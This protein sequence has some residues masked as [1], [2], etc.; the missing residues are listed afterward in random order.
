MGEWQR[1]EGESAEGGV[2]EAGLCTTDAAQQIKIQLARAKRVLQRKAES[3]ARAAKP[4]IPEAGGAPL[5]P[6]VRQRMEG[7]LGG[8]LS[9]VRVHN[10]AESAQ[11]ATAIGARA[12]TD[13]RDVHFNAG[14]YAPDS[15]EGVR[16]LAHELTH[17]VQGQHPGLQRKADDREAT[18]VSNPEDPAEKEADAVG[19]RVADEEHGDKAAQSPAAVS[20]EHLGVS[21][22]IMRAEEEGTQDG[23]TGGQDAEAGAGEN[24]E[25]GAGE[26]A[27]AGTGENAEA[28][29][30][31][32]A[33]AGTGEN[34]E[35]GTGENAE[36]GT[37]ESAGVENA[38]AGGENAE[39][40]PGGQEQGEL[41]EGAIDEELQDVGEKLAELDQAGAEQ[42]AAQPAG[43]EQSG[44][45]QAGPADPA[46]TQGDQGDAAAGGD[47]AGAYGLAT[48]VAMD[49]FLEEARSVQ[50]N[51][52]DMSPED[53]MGDLA[54][55]ANAELVSA[56][57]CPLDFGLLDLGFLD[58]K[59]DRPNW[60]MVLNKPTFEKDSINQD[61]AANLAETVYHEARHAEQTNSVARMLVG[62]QMSTPEI[63]AKLNVP[64]NV[65]D[66]A[67]TK[68]ID[69]QSPEA[70]LAADVYKSEYGENKEETKAVYT[71]YQ[72]ALIALKNAQQAMK[73]AVSGTQEY[74]DA[75][76]EYNQAKREFQGAQR[77]YKSLPDEQDAYDV[78]GKLKNKFLAG[79]Q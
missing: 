50:S 12:F 19:E 15:K 17:V 43:A 35:A 10:G 23:E 75:Q 36:A 8:D 26:N 29:T 54:R 38:Q 1:R 74:S 2:A 14:Q 41:P 18:E 13:G 20:T 58:G 71:R 67:R 45:Q 28:G 27:E 69:P 63:V 9:G 59:F 65:V 46:Q 5:A 24:A 37:A 66:Q 34:A 77:D 11:A 6:E 21:R 39:A 31:E 30:G 57:V 52:A 33:E 72:S 3:Q 51:W 22:K 49:A 55:G 79:N 25:A 44:A 40:A 32:N 78:G 53:R 7:H 64:Q 60:K 70:Q 48:E 16:L 42:G 47:D 61:E 73:N 56:G 68:P 4:I 62:K 76:R